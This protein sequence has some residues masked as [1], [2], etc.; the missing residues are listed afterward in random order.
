[1]GKKEY[2]DVVRNL[3]TIEMEHFTQRVW[4][5]Q[6]RKNNLA[7]GYYKHILS[8]HKALFSSTCIDLVAHKNR[9]V[10]E[11]E[12]CMLKRTLKRKVM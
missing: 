10:F 5:T 8:I 2:C 4:G 1:M 6:G 7:R 11:I 3:E 12:E 9:I